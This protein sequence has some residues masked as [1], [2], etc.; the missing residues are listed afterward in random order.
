MSGLHQITITYQDS[1]TED[2]SIADLAG[3][4]LKVTQLV[5]KLRQVL[6]IPAGFVEAYLKSWRHCI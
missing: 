3:N 1:H 4:P 2:W 6:G 5:V